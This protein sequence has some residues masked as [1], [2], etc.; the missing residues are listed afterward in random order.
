[1]KMLSSYKSYLFAAAALGVLGVAAIAQTLPNL[2][3]VTTVNTTDLFQDVVRGDPVTNSYFAT[4]AQIAGVPGYVKVVP[5]TAFSLTFANTQ[6][7][8][9]LNPAGTLATGTLT[10]AAQPSDG[11]RECVLSSQTQTALTWS[12][13]TG[14]TINNAPTALVANTPVCITYSA[15]NLTWDRSP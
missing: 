5:L 6:T 1:M 7:D 15:S 10:T 12:A 4:A 2:P 9:I 3:K 8:M 13:N 14:Q 11:Q